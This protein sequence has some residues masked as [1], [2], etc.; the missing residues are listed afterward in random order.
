VVGDQVVHDRFGS[1][2]V[3]RVEGEGSHSR[4]T[5]NF[6]EHGTKQLILAMTPLQRA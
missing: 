1:G 6:D 3:V 2:V 4:A 5:V